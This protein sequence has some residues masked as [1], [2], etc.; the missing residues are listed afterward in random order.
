M[1]QTQSLSLGGTQLQLRRSQQRAGRSSCSTQAA[2]RQ[3]RTIREDI[4]KKRLQKQG[5][6]A[7]TVGSPKPQ[8]PTSAPPASQEGPNYAVAAAVALLVPL[9]AW[10]A[11]SGGQ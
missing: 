4:D 5:V 11:L 6:V 2:Q 8:P 3:F 10:L 1:L 9:V 7:K